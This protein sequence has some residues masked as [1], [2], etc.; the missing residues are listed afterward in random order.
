VAGI[1]VSARLEIEDLL[2]EFAAR[3]DEGRG[4]TVHELFVDAGRVETPQFV[5]G[6]REEIRERFTARAKDATRKSRHYWSNA[7]FSGSETEVTVVTN[8]MTVTCVQDRP[9]LLTGGSS[10]DVV[11]RHGATWAFKSRRLDV[12]FEGTLGAM[13]APR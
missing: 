13:E 2:S 12:L 4:A 6:S 3:V 10:T 7:K 8:V 1:P 5:L 9:T 11:V